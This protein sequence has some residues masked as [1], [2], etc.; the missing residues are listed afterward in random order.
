MGHTFVRPLGGLVANSSTNFLYSTLD[1]NLILG[2]LKLEGEIPV[3][4]T[5]PLCMQPRVCTVC[6]L[7]VCMYPFCFVT[8][9]NIP[10]QVHDRT[11]LKQQIG[12][13]G[14]VFSLLGSLHYCRHLQVVMMMS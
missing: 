8:L 14:R 5:T 2:G 3:R 10:G 1:S 11:D 7:Y 4:P 6:N 13:V 9:P 12:P